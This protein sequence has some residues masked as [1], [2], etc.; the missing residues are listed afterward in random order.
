MKPQW[1]L[2]WVP[3]VGDV[4]V[5]GAGGLNYECQAGLWLFVRYRPEWDATGVSGLRPTLG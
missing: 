4:V 2:R 5:L 3:A 1:R